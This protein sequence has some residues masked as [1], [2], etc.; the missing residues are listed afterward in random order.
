MTVE[1]L[2][3]P[4]VDPKRQ[5]LLDRLVKAREARA[6]KRR[7]EPPEVPQFH[8][9]T[10]RK[11]VTGDNVVFEGRRWKV[12]VTDGSYIQRGSRVVLEC[13]D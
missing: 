11:Y 4:E 2:A 9:S 13:I 10:R 8:P 1:V 6:A 12:A 3:E 7:S 5:A